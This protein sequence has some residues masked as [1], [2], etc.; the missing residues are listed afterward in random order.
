MIEEYEDNI[1]S[2]LVELEDTV[3]IMEVCKPSEKPDYISKAKEKISNIKSELDLYNSE[4]QIL[5][6]GEQK[7]HKITHDVL[8]NDLK[9]IEN[10]FEMK[11]MAGSHLQEELQNMGNMSQEDL[12]KKAIKHGDKLLNARKERANNIL[13][14]LNQA[15][16]L[17]TDIND[18]IREQNQRLMD[19][20]EIIKDSQSTLVRANELVG[21]FAKAFYRDMFLKILII[22]IAIAIIALVVASVSKKKAVKDANV[23]PTPA[24]TPKRLLMGSH[25]AAESGYLKNIQGYLDGRREKQEFNLANIAPKIE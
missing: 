8:E 13:F 24:P 19:M 7:E 11:K 14:T 9:R 16:M 5:D 18:E 2:M 15:N 12:Q 20:E 17:V 4:I 1:K 22:L 21:F 10:E 25:A 23:T 3:K 6:H